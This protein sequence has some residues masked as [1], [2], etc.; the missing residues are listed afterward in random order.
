MAERK[1]PMYRVYKLLLNEKGE[2]IHKTPNVR[3]Q[4]L[5]TAMMYARTNSNGWPMGVYEI[6]PDG[7][8]VRVQ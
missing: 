6:K 8:E 7:T 3:C 5:K 2:I 4:F 1:E